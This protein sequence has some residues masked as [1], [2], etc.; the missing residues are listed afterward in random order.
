MTSDQ[1]QAELFATPTWMSAHK[2]DERCRP[3]ADRHYNRRKV[4]S[5]QFVPPGR[6]AVFY[7]SSDAG[8]AFWVTSW[9]FAEYVRHAWGGAWV[10]SAFR[11]ESSLRASDLISAAVRSTREVFGEPPELGMITFIDTKK[12]RPVMVRGKATWGRTW[13]LA[14]FHH[15]GW[16]K[17]GLMAW[18]LLPEDMHP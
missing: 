13:G 2:F 12:V 15:A 18:Q 10:C 14:G 8:E 6:S 5:P 16:T 17:G 11:N 3:L 1:V 7:H 4:G 9:P